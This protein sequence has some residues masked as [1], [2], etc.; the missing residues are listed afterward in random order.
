VN[1]VRRCTDAITPI[2]NKPS[3][4]HPAQRREGR[5]CV[6]RDYGAVRTC[7]CQ[8][9]AHGDVQRGVTANLNELFNTAS[10]A[11][12]PEDRCAPHQHHR[13]GLAPMP[14]S[15]SVRGRWCTDAKPEQAR[16]LE[17]S[18]SHMP[19]ELCASE[20]VQSDVT[21]IPQHSSVGANLSMQPVS[22]PGLQPGLQPWV[23][24]RVG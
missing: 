7:A 24:T 13:W 19:V 12:N 22:Q 18:A 14:T 4:T 5:E 11:I 2:R 1:G 9:T 17:L 8:G 10:P 16:R 21:V 6:S 20:G 3:F 15:V 23:V